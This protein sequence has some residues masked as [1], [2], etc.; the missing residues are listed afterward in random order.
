[1]PRLISRAELSRLARVSGAAITKA[2]RG[3]LSAA[4]VLE[5]IDLEHAAVRAYLAD[6][7]VEVPPA[8][9]QTTMAETAQNLTESQTSTTDPDEKKAKGRTVPRRRRK[10][11]P[12][13]EG[14][15]AED[16]A[17]LDDLT[18]RQVA[19]RFGHILGF[20]VYVENGVARERWREKKLRN[21]ESDGRLIPRDLVE[22]HI[23]EALRD[24]NSRLLEDAPRTV[25]SKVL[26]AARAG[27][28]LEEVERIF[29][30]EMSSQ[31]NPV[32]ERI[33]KA[34]REA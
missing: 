20:K 31:L 12:E 23:M 13:I 25:A 28:T 4:K 17:Q 32:K 19:Q 11:F 30:D 2:C 22:I 7:G 8:L 34:L 29:T 10:I 5:G 18:L 14:M 9:A 3:S 27:A 33:A 26:S 1:M 6:K 24:L 15:S 16:I 21:D